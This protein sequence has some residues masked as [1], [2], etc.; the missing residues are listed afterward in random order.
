MAP[1]I[2]TMDPIANVKQIE[3]IDDQFW[4]QLHNKVAEYMNSFVSANA[5]IQKNLDLKVAHINRVI[6]NSEKIGNSLL[7]EPEQIH[8]TKIIA[9][10]HDVGRFEQMIQY[11]TF[12]DAE[13]VDHAQLG[14]SIIKQQNWLTG[15]EE[16][17]VE[18][19]LNAIAYHNKLELPEKLKQEES[20][21]CKIIRDADKIDILN[22][23]VNEYSY[24][25]RDKNELFSYQLKDTPV[26]SKKI[27]NRIMD[28]KLPLNKDLQTLTDFKLLQLSFVY[29]LYFK[30]SYSII[31]EQQLLKKLFDTMPKSDQIFEIYRKVR[32]YFENKLI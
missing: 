3:M 11:E 8:L 28:E 29:D 24:Q 18:I 16:K 6:G 9:L 27:V 17:F 26:A 14:I 15:L 21:F 5:L 12:N 4:T 22:I 32:I 23:A 7:L 13:S 2:K 20:L 1:K 10:L 19:I 31:N 30:K 25:N